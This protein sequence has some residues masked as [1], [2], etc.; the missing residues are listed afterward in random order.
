MGPGADKLEIHAVCRLT[1]TRTKN[2][3]IA[4]IKLGL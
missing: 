2:V 3:N 1:E 4:C